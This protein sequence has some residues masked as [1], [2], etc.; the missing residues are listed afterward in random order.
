MLKITKIEPVGGYQLRLTYADGITGVVDL[1][2]LVGKGV[3]RLWNDPQAF[4]RVRIGSGG[5]V[6]WSDEVQLCADA[7]YLELTGKSVDELFSKLGKTP[8]NA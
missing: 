2:H 1:S 7:L 4:A 6:H 5:E 3:F 8:I